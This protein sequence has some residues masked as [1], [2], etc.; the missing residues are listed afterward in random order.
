MVKAFIFSGEQREYDNFIQENH[1]DR[2][3]YP[4]LREENWQGYRDVEIIRIGTFY[5]DQRLHSM[6]YHIETQLNP[7][8][9]RG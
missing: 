4:R 1:L 9:I 7:P 2:R 6:L 5:Q 3:I 8:K